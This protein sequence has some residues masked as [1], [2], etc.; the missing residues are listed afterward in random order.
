MDHTAGVQRESYKQMR[1]G[2]LTSP[3]GIWIREFAIRS[4]PPRVLQ[5]NLRTANVFDVDPW[6]QRFK[7][8]KAK[9]ASLGK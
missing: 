5:K 8:V 9:R 1:L 3:V 7:A 4:I 6:L 2:Q